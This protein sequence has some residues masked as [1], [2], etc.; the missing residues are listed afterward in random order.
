MLQ[1]EDLQR[2]RPDHTLNKIILVGLGGGLALILV[3]LYPL[4]ILLPGR[5]VDGWA[6]G[7]SAL[8]FLLGIGAVLL[9][10]ATGLLAARWAGAD[11]RQTG[12]LYGALAG[13][14]VGAI[15]FF[16]LGGVAAAVAGNAPLLVHGLGLAASDVEAVRLLSEAVIGVTWGVYGAF[17]AA[18]LAGLGLGAIGG[19][20][21]PP[22]GGAP[23]RLDPRLVAISILGAAGLFSALTLC[24]S[25]P[26]FGL[27]ETAILRASTMYALGLGT[28]L[29]LAGV[30]LWPVGTQG[31]LCA[32]SGAASRG[33]EPAARATGAHGR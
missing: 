32:R 11:T 14:L 24:A 18:L 12:L 3:L 2:Y 27:L 29:P 10:A 25:L 31:G 22:T 6:A 16:G 21:A 33:A 23:P 17:W 5:Y 28:T 7:S 20:L 15:C 4:Y 30:T 13:G 19:L 26:V 1:A 9:A 8:S